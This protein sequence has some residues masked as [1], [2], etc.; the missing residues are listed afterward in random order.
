MAEGMKRSEFISV[1]GM[2]TSVIKYG[3]IDEKSSDRRLFLIIPG[4]FFKVVVNPKIPVPQI[5]FR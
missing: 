3:D 4:E 5:R 1:L 2:P